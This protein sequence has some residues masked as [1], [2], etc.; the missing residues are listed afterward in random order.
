M[1]TALLCSPPDL[2]NL[3]FRRFPESGFCF[4]PGETFGWRE[5]GAG[6]ENGL[7]FPNSG[8]KSSQDQQ[9]TPAGPPLQRHL[10]N[11]NKNK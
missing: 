10:R 1:F 3:D 4:S 6:G 5:G 7:I 9:S 8:G 2:Q 11:K